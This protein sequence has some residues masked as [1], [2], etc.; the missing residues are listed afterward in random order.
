MEV[1]VYCILISLLFNLCQKDGIIF[2][3]W[4]KENM[5]MLYTFLTRYAWCPLLLFMTIK[6]NKWSAHYYFSIFMQVLSENPNYTEALIGRGTAYAFKREL[7]AAIDDFTM[8]IFIRYDYL[9]ILLSKSASCAGYQVQFI[10]WRS[11]EA[12][13]TGSCCTRWIWGGKAFSFF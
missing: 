10:C 11:L 3:R 5:A 13:G 7:E 1:A 2:C 9:P 12:A 6:M 8:V 4:M